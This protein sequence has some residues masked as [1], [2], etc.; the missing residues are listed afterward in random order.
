[1]SA[2]GEGAP[3]ESAPRIF[4]AE[5]I[6]MDAMRFF[7]L[8]ADALACDRP[9]AEAVTSVVFRELRERLTVAEAG[10][11]AAQLPEALRRLWWEGASDAAHEKIPAA[12]MLGRVRRRAALP[13]DREAERAVRA[14]FA[15]LRLALGSATGV[16][17]EAW[18]VFSVL[19]K[20]IKMLWMPERTGA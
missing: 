11:V 4:R 12:E 5:E 17:G 16:E 7:D 13:D 15:A 18:H 9:R 10:D 6:I 19:P 8:V 1:M 14:V 20:D 2:A 3:L